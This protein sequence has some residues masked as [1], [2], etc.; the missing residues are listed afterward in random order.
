MDY[1]SLQDFEVNVQKHAKAQA[2]EPHGAIAVSE[3][4]AAYVHRS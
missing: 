4:L 2:D 1:P 3:A